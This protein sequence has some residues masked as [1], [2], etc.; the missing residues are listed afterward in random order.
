MQLILGKDKI[1]GDHKNSWQNYAVF[2]ALG[3]E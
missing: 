1:T 2:V 3:T